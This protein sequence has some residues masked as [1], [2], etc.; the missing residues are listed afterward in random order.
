M[1]KVQEKTK[2]NKLIDSGKVMKRYS[3]MR[4]ITIDD[5]K[6]S[7]TFSLVLCM[8]NKMPKPVQ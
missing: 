6:K 8:I 7:F 3:H 1:F 2:P 5:K 4:T